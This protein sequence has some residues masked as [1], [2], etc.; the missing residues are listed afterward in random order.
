[1]G[2]PGTAVGVR[3]SIDVPSPI[4]GTGTRLGLDGHDAALLRMELVD[5]KGRLASNSS[6]VV[7]FEI[8]SGPGRVAGI[9]NGDP[10]SHRHQPGSTTETY[11]GL[12]RAIIQADVD[13]SSLLRN[14]VLQIDADPKAGRRT[15][16]LLD[17]PTDPIVVAV[18][19][20]GLGRNTVSIPV[21]G[22]MAMDG[23][24]AVASQ[25]VDLNTFTY[26]D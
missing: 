7:T 14:M 1:M 10:A 22:D 18:S 8:V 4:T 2:S 5:S 16:V 25:T 3:L 15:R 11:G 13:C 9:G 19:A 24:E 20:P 23:P 21:S 12:A 6:A 26:I 17:C